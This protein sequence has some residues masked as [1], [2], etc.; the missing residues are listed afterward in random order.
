[1]ANRYAGK[2]SSRCHGGLHARWALH[3]WRDESD[4][5]QLARNAACECRDCWHQRHHRERIS[6]SRK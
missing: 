3:C 4:R 1:L 2:T 5:D 6:A